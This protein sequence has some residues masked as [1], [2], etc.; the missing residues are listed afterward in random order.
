MLHIT[1]IR[2]INYKSFKQFSLTL[3]DFNILVGP[4]NAGKSTVIGS[5][6]VLAEGIRKAKSRKPILVLD[7]KGNQVLGYEIDLSQVP[8][9]TENVFHNY[10]DAQ[11]AQ[12]RFRLSD[13]AYLQVYF[14]SKSTCYLNY[15]SDK[16][17]I[18]SPKEFLQFVNIDIGYVPILGPV[19]HTEKLY[20]K[21]AARLALLTHT[22]S[23]N[24]RNIWYHYREDFDKFR[25]LIRTTWPGLDIS[26]PELNT[27]GKDTT[28]D[29]FCPEDRIPREIYW[30]GFGFQVW[31]QML[32]YIIKNKEVSLFLID[33]PDIYL[34]SD[35]QRQLLGILKAL[36]PDIVI[37]THSTELISEADINDILLINKSNN[38]AKR[39]KDPS[40]LRNIFQVLGSNLN[41]VLTQIAKTKKVLFVEGKDFLIFSKIARTLKMEHVANR[42]DFAVV[43]VEGFNPTRL[44]AFKDGIEKTIGAKIISAVIF[45]KDYRSIDEVKSEYEELS[46]G[47]FFAHIHSRKEIE[48]FLLVPKAIERAIQNRIDEVNKRTGKSLYFNEDIETFLKALSDEF[49]NKTQA[50]LQAHRFK[51]EKS[52]NP[53]HDESTIIEKI[54][55]EF[56]IT[57][58]S[59]DQRLTVISGKDFLSRLNAVLQEKLKVTITSANIISAMTADL[60]P[61]EMKEIIEK[62]NG[63]RSEQI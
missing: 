37:A 50:Q 20:Q 12:I 9:A 7:P 19:E 43:P 52:I 28:V 45:D 23:R 29:M 1:S 54:L 40:Q 55:H 8:V 27:S 21:E 42:S 44:H 17:I 31:C 32:T 2:F 38:S 61:D 13:G 15:E 10:D 26:E 24:F 39:I 53:K 63:L 49:K 30:A 62:I 5:L 60:I 46:K 3:S 41:P 4:N 25:D 59:F 57:W 58:N 11:P 48:N 51:F 47:N 14:T 33:E 34:H 35:L 6:K 36:G 22:A 56:E 18:R 16:R